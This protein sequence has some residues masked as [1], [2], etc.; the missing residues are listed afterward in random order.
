MFN[1]DAE[2]EEG[3]DLSGSS[4][5]LKKLSGDAATRLTSAG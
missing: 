3:E 4:E 1:R 5:T 2:D